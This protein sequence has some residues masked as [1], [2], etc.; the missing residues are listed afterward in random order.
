MLDWSLTY[1]KTTVNEPRTIFFSKAIRIYRLLKS[2]MKTLL[3]VVW[4]KAEVT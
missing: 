4:E 3:H 1:G 2:Y